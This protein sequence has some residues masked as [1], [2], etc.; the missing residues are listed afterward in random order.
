MTKL[1]WEAVEDHNQSR[2]AN[3]KSGYIQYELG[4]TCVGLS[5]SKKRENHISVIVK[6]NQSEEEKTVD[7]KLIV[8][9]DGIRSRVRECLKEGK[10]N[11]SFDAWDYNPK[12][13]QL[14]TWKNPATGLKLKVSESSLFAYEEPIS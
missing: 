14:K 11:C 9:A 10:N 6:S 1:L 4:V 3:G 13:F 8:G 7:G 12:K 2:D 5:P